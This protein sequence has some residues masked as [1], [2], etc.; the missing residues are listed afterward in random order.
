VGTAMRPAGIVIGSGLLLLLILALPSCGYRLAADPE[1]RFGAAALRVDLRPLANLTAFPDAGVAVASAVREEMRRSGFRG[2]FEAG[3]PDY[4]IEGTVRDA[5]FE[6]V[7]HDAAGFALEHRLIL[8]VDI[9]V[10]EV[11]RGRIIWREEGLTESVSYYGG[12][13]YQFTESNLRMAMDEAAG[14]LARRIGQ[15]LRVIL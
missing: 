4:R 8:L 15:T 9:R 12:A 13:D 3:A 10:V 6:V 11:L 7:S 2:T 1:S 14:R 5:R